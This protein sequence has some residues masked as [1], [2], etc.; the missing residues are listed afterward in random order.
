M[1]HSSI[2]PLELLRSY[3]ALHGWYDKAML[4]Y[5][6]Y[7]HIQIAGTMRAEAINNGGRNA[8]DIS[9]RLLRHFH[10]L[11]VS[12]PSET[13]IK[14]IFS[15][16]LQWAMNQYGP[17]FNRF[18]DDLVNLSNK[19]Y[20]GIVDSMIP[21]PNK[22]HYIFSLRD[23]MKVFQ[24][25]IKIVPTTYVALGEDLDFN[26]RRLLIY[27]SWINETMRTYYD[28][29]ISQEDKKAFSN[30]MSS[31][32]EE[33]K[34]LLEWESLAKDLDSIYFGYSMLQE[35]GKIGEDKN[36]YKELNLQEVM[37]NVERTLEV[38]Q[39]LFKKQIIIFMSAIK[40]MIAI[41]RIFAICK[42][43]GMLIGIGGNGRATL[44][45]LACKMMDW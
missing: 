38:N 19:I 43:N 10:V 39:G 44:S 26:K 15:S 16:I 42:F 17:E 31:V 37:K 12:L 2:S 33:S 25:M 4:E 1:H 21:V 30:L 29:L 24:G 27:K 3:L 23:I 35:E 36:E 7:Q 32:I 20:Q 11:Y 5:K 9:P 28:K 8:C 22:C 13:T 6:E 34:H 14:Y 45:K 40:H 18:A 41:G